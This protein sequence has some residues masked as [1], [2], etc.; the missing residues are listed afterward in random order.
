MNLMGTKIFASLALA[1]SLV[2]VGPA[3]GANIT[4][5]FTGNSSGLGTGNLGVSSA[6][7]TSGGL[8]LTVEAV[9][10]FGAAGVL[11]RNATT[12]LGVVG[13]PGT[14][15]E[16][17]KVGADSNGGEA[18]DLD[19]SPT[20]VTILET[21]VFELGREAG[22]LNVFADNA[23]VETISWTETTG[24]GSSGN[25]DILHTFTVPAAAR[26]GQVFRFQAVEDSFRLKT[27]TVVEIPEPASLALFA[28]GLAGVAISSRQSTR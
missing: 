15:A 12:G 24:G 26:T 7:V 14:G 27:L 18:L 8:N 9:D 10:E 25:S 21:V 20:T 1:L 11:A 17:N 22:S 4:Y 23:L 5:D 13:E 3:H 2:V 6:S 19:F 16:T 28:L